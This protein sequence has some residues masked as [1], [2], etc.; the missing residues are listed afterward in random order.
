MNPTLVAAALALAAL[1]P[2]GAAAQTHMK[3]SISVARNSHQSVAI[4]V[5]AKEIEQRTNGRIKIQNSNAGV[6][7]PAALRQAFGSFRTL[8]S[9]LS[10]RAA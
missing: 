9:G 5:F 2:L 3:N 7:S 8:A 4:D 10:P 1:L 6:K